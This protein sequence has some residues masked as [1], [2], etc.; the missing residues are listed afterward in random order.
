MSK[1]LINQFKEEFRKGFRKFIYDYVK[2][3]FDH[4]IIRNCNG[5]G[6]WS[7]SDATV[8]Y[9]KGKTFP[10]HVWFRS[11]CMDLAHKLLVPESIYTTEEKQMFKCLIEASE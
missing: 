2:Q 4:I 11:V 6:P 8:E 1:D 10:V 5:T 9:V 7:F 3:E